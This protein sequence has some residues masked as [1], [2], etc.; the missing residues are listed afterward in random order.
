MYCVYIQAGVTVYVLDQLTGDEKL[1]MCLSLSS[2]TASEALE[3]SFI[4]W[5]HPAH[6]QPGCCVDLVAR[7]G[8]FGKR[9][10]ILIP[11][12]PGLGHSYIHVCTHT[13]KEQSTQEEK[14]FQFSLT[15]TQLTYTAEQTAPTPTKN[16]HTHA[17][18]QSFFSIIHSHSINMHAGIMTANN[19]LIGGVWVVG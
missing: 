3:Y 11:L 15:T 18:K 1:C 19:I 2:S 4:S 5:L 8:Q 10:S 14:L 16:S 17:F 6:R 12:H 13:K 9:H 7:V